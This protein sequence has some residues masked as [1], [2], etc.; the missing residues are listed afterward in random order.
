MLDLLNLNVL[1]KLVGHIG[2]TVDD[3]YKA[4]KR[5]ERLG[6]EFVKRPDDGTL[7]TQF[8]HKNYSLINSFIC[9]CTF[10][11]FMHEIVVLFCP[12]SAGK[13]K[14]IAFIKDPD[15]YWIEIFDL[16]IIGGVASAAS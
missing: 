10:I 6:V 2:I 13:M 16:K 8:S 12:P 4:C 1:S 9:L 14:G 7:E 5:F 11:L 3:T 15:G